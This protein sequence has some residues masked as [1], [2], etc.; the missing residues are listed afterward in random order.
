[1]ILELANGDPKALFKFE[2]AYAPP[3]ST[4]LDP[5]HHFGAMIDAGH[6][7]LVSPEEFREGGEHTWTVINLLSDDENRVVEFPEIRGHYV[8]VPIRELR[9][10]V[11]EFPKKD[12]ITVCAR[13]PRSYEA[14]IFLR[15]KGI[16]ARYVAGGLNLVNSGEL[17]G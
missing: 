13:G 9:K 17:R 14:A 7:L 10:R 16:E 11:D 12:V 15:S 6:D 3:Y 8:N 4:A 1:M 2:H 5:L